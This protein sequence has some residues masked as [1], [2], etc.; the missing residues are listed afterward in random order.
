MKKVIA[1][2]LGA[3]FLLTCFALAGQKEKI[4][5]A[6]DGETPA[7]SV[8]GQPARSPYFLFFDEK[9]KMI[10]AVANPARDGIAAT[11]FL[12]GK[13]VTVAV[14]GEYGPQIIDIMKKKGIKAVAFKGSAEEA[15]KKVLQPK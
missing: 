10:E 7:A 12:A 13:G 2:T 9:G 15:V 6:A 4:A 5:V 14:A 8:S 1:V 3:L 11:E